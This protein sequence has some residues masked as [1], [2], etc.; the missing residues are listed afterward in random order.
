MWE[1]DS[2]RIVRIIDEGKQAMKKSEKV[3]EKQLV[4]PGFES[5]VTREARMLLE[6]GEQI[7]ALGEHLRW[8]PGRWPHIYNVQCRAAIRD[9][10]EAMMLIKA[11]GESG[12]LIAFHSAVT[13][14]GTL[15]TFTSRARAGKVT[16]K[17]DE[18]PPKN[19]EEIAAGVLDQVEHI[20]KTYWG[21]SQGSVDPDNTSPTKG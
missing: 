1:S 3:T 8:V 11:V 20:R 19:Y 4:L 13:I 12:P 7:E 14:V 10:S 21:R 9:D 2:N 17:V 18:H 6:K 16:W 5:V 15:V